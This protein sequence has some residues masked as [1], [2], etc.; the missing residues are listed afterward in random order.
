MKELAGDGVPVTVT[1]RVLKL[2]RQPYYRWLGKPVTDAV[3]EEA[4]RANALFAAHREDPE[5]G[6]RF[7]AGEARSTGAAMADR[8]AWRMSH[9]AGA[10][11]A[12]YSSAMP[13]TLPH[14]GH[15]AWPNRCV[16]PQASRC[17][18]S[19]T[20]DSCNILPVPVSSCKTAGRRGTWWTSPRCQSR[21]EE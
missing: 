15:S 17:W 11:A 18:P 21:I 13:K 19:R 8:T 10:L 14:P 20:A 16:R 7:L 2:A 6:Y 1:C 5:F 3:L 12:S 9:G 4:Y